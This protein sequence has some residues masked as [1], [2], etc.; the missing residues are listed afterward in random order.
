MDKALEKV[1]C[2]LTPTSPHPAFKIGEQSDNPVKMYLEDI[3]VTNASLA[4]LPAISI[5]AGFSGKLPIGMQLIGKRL[6]EEKLFSIA[7][8]FEKNRT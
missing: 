6:D 8:V 1:D 7:S 4:G 5:P 2:I 3:F